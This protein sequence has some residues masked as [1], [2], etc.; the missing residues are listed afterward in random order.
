VDSD[1]DD[2]VVSDI[3]GDA[4]AA[5]D[6]FGVVGVTVVD[7]VIVVVDGAVGD[8]SDCDTEFDGA[9]D[10][11]VAGDGVGVVV[12][13]DVR[14]WVI[15]PDGLVVGADVD[16]VVVEVVEVVSTPGPTFA[17]GWASRR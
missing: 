1:A 15:V 5:G 8:V 16:E 12:G 3:D 11:F 10:P 7:G 14:D 2:G 9:V 6:T 17:P 13:A 4:A